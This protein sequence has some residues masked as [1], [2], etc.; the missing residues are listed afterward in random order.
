[1][2]ILKKL[3]VYED[4]FKR[5]AKSYGKITINNLGEKGRMH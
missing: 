3:G 4:T 1:M 2:S 5:C